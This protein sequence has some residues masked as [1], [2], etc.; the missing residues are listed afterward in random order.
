MHR[1]QVNL[2]MIATKVSSPED[3]ALVAQRDYCRSL[4]DALAAVPGGA[5]A[6]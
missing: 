3:P 1:E 4:R 2:A 5:S 6:R